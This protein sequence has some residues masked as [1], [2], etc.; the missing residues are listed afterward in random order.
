MYF[1][2]MELKKQMACLTS[3]SVDRWC[4][5]LRICGKIMKNVL[6]PLQLQYEEMSSRSLLG[7]RQVMVLTAFDL[8]SPLG[9]G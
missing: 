7:S 3:V 1:P 2:D 5:S 9:F 4:V 8:A 6:F